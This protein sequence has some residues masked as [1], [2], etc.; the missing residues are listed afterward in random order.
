MAVFPVSQKN[1]RQVP[2]WWRF[3]GEKGTPNQ[4]LLITK[5]L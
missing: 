5:Q 2:F 1:V 3:F 4:H